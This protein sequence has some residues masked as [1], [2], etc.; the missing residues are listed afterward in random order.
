MLPES[1][2]DVVPDDPRIAQVR[3]LLT[4]LERGETAEADRALG[5][6]ARVHDTGLFQE[7][8]R[9][10]RE[11]HEALNAFRYDTRLLDLAKV[12]IPDA[13]ERLHYVIDMT[14]QAASRTL[15]AVEQA[16]PVCEEIRSRARGLHEDWR[17]FLQRK[18]DVTE[19]R[20]LSARLDEFLPW[21][22]A[23]VARLG[24]GLSEV[25]MAQEFQDLTGQVIRR[26]IR[27]VEEVEGSLVNLVR[28]SGQ[29]LGSNPEPPAKPADGLDGPQIPGRHQADAVSGQDEVDD[30][31]SSLG[32]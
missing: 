32:F 22:E 12:D 21:A 13:K 17:R 16:R 25:L 10:T 23:G 15:N 30:L 18:M 7:V 31:L 19:F 2:A 14:E 26:V 9:L 24:S 5:D 8:G 6:L 4:H 28:I 27:L 3:E 1:A 29:R 11:L 20:T